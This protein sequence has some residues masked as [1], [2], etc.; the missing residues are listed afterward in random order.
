MKKAILLAFVCLVGSTVVYADENIKPAAQVRYRFESGGRDFDKSTGNRNFSLLRSRL[1]MTFTKEDLEVVVMV[2][3]ARF[4]GEETST[5]FDGNADNFDLREGFMK[6]KRFFFSPLDLK[7]GRMRVKYGEERLIGAVEWSNIGRSFD[8]GVLTLH[9]PSIS[10]DVF[11]FAQIESLLVGDQGD[12]HVVGLNARFWEKDARTNQVYVIGQVKDQTN[13]LNRWTLGYYIKGKVGNLE[14]ASNGAYQ[15]GVFTPD[16]VKQDVEAYMLTA[17]LWY[18][19][20]QVSGKP[21][22]SVGV[23]YLSGDDDLTDTNFKVF[24]TMYATN[25]KFYGFMDYFLNIPLNTF[26]RGLV[27]EY[28]RAQIHLGPV[29]VRLDVHYFLAAEDFTLS[30]GGTSKNFGTEVDLTF[31]HNYNEYLTI[32]GGASLFDPGEIFKDRRGSD[33]ANW[34]YIMLIANI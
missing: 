31:K 8:G 32:W 17:D 24:D 3:D 15:T 11:A 9:N 16:S 7:L 27:D 2:Q 12:L 29:P 33:V 4:M 14:Y 19:F 28:V 5:L 10:V 21:G 13:Q 25:H 6:V 22:V 1:G 20:P 30:T 34:A 18:R 23:D 26:G